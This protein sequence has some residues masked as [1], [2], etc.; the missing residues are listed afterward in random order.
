LFTSADSPV[1]IAVLS[2]EALSHQQLEEC[3][4]DRLSWQ[5]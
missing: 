1:D 3:C 5:N 4:I 2:R